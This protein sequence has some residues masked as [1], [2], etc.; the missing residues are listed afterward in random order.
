MTFISELIVFKH[1]F[2]WSIVA[3][4]DMVSNW[5]RY[6]DMVSALRIDMVSNWAR[7]KKRYSYCDIGIK[8]QNWET[9]KFNF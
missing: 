3:R 2:F 6:I 7:Y 9:L 1:S 5:V 8:I 4:L